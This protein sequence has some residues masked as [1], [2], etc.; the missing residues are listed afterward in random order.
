M[1]PSSNIGRLD[2]REN[3]YI[4][5]RKKEVIVLSSG[6]NIYPDELEAHYLQSPYI[7]EIAVIGIS[8]EASRGEKLHAVV[9]PNFDYLKLQKITNA[10]E[11]LRDQIAGLSNQLPK[12]KRLMS[13]QIQREALPR[14]TTRKIKRLELKKLIEDDQLKS[15]EGP[16]LPDTASLEDQALMESAVGREVLSCLR[17]TYHREKAI[18]AGMNLEL[19]LGFDSMER[20][21]LLA[22]LEQRLSLELPDEFGVE[23][24]TVR[25]LISRLAE[26]TG[27][28]SAS[29][30]ASR[31]SW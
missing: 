20:V 7:Q 3:L 29:G 31:Q 2:E 9:V 8:D 21:E 30:A 28:E 15:M 26:Q 24:F 12:Y 17:E 18:D 27:A 10:K 16:A 13:Y 14:T 25:D 1:R 19:D 11:I 5:G 6:K 23:I 4:T 22:S